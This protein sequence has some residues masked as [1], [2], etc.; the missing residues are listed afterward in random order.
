MDQGSRFLVGKILGKG[1]S[2]NV[3]SSQYIEFYQSHWLQYFG[4]PDFLRFDAEGTWRSREID[5]YFSKN[6]V[7]LDPI[8]GD[9]HWHLSPLERS[10]AWLKELLSRLAQETSSISTHEAAHQALNIWNRREMVRG[11]S[12]HQHALGQAPDLDGRFFRDDVRGLPV[13]IMETPIGELERHQGLRLQAEET[14]LKWQAKERLARAMNSK[15]KPIPASV[16]QLRKASNRETILA[17]LDK[18]LRLPWTISEIVAPLGKN[19]YDD[20]TVEAKDMP[21]EEDKERVARFWEPPT[22]RHRTKRPVELPGEEEEVQEQ[23]PSLPSR[24]TPMDI[25]PEEDPLLYAKGVEEEHQA[26]WNDE[27]AYVEMEIPLPQS[28]HGWM[29]MSKDV[30]AYIVNTLKKKSVEVFERHMDEDTKVKFQG[31]KKTE[32]S[33]FLASEALEALPA[34][35]QPPKTQA[36]S[37]R[38]WHCWKGDVAA[39]F[40]QGRICEEELYCIPTPDLCKEMNIPPE[41][42]TRLRKSCYGLVQAPYE[43]YETVKT[44]FHE[45]GYRQCFSDPCCWVLKQ[46]GEVRSII[47]GHVDDFVFIGNP[48]DEYWQRAKKSIQDAFRQY[49]RDELAACSSSQLGYS[50]LVFTDLLRLLDVPGRESCRGDDQGSFVRQVAEHDPNV[51]EESGERK[52]EPPQ[53]ET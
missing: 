53:P 40:L 23:N 33:K 20:I 21:S 38:G 10:I 28:R 12:P 4:H 30:K 31:A 45:L 1:E 17:E 34:R 47:S 52:Q 42:I 22:K 3:K 15:S 44:H 50:Q 2:S 46:E 11:F 36:M 48:Q 43:W 25:D 18:D 24:P 7:M 13:E 27:K 37:M 35:L 41:S 32:I 49:L 39:A 9:A 5:S 6:Q 26:F 8:P 19:E 51:F 16:E 14:F 29:Q